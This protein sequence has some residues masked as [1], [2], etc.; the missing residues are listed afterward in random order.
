MKSKLLQIIFW[1]LLISFSNHRE[2]YSQ[3]F[4]MKKISDKVFIVSNPDLGNQVVV[5]SEKG[6][7]IF[8]SFWSEKTAEMFKE[9]ISKN[10]N[11]NDFLYVIN[12]VDRLDMIGGNAAYQ[13]SIIVGH[14]NI[15]TKYNR[16]ELVKKGIAESIEM[17]REKEGYSRNRLQNLETGSEKAL[18]EENW[19]NKCKT[20]ADELENSFSLV[21]PK[22]SYND[23]MTLDLGNI[24]INLFWFGNAGNYQGL[25]M[26]V[27]PQEKITIISKAIVYPE[28]HLAPYPFPYYG[29]LDVPR[30]IAMLGQIL[31]G[32]NPVDNII[33]SDSFE[34]YSR[35]LMRSHLNYIRKLWNTVKALE[36]EGKTLQEIQDQLSL[37]KD[38]AFIKEMQVYKNMND[39]WIRPQHELHVRLFFLQG[40][41]LASEIIKDGGPESLQASLNKIKKAGSSIYFDEISID[42]IGYE[43]MNMGNISGSIEIFKLNV[44]VFPR[45]YSAF[46]SLGEAYMKNGDKMTAKKN[47]EKSLE[48]NPQN[49]N[50]KKIL[51]QLKKVN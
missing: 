18:K 46:N 12:M 33:L 23:K 7:V 32:E 10:L 11:R 2:L 40:K 37:E 6:L 38:F 19:M 41:T 30:W 48:L 1:M 45:S 3:G 20:M 4:Q 31:E 27:I 13:E 47:I 29:I 21:L 36:S 50:A 16:E 42:R 44:E 51:E 24:K 34:I 15:I 43:W 17:W 8:D 26:A 25:T 49:E 28:Y 14:E 35:E 39:N 9:E 5:Q 22:I